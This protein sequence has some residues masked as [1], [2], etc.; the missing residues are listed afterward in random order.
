MPLKFSHVVVCT[1]PNKKLIFIFTTSQHAKAAT[2]AAS[3]T[4]DLLKLLDR[5]R[6]LQ[7][8]ADAAAY[9]L[10]EAKVGL[11]SS[12][13]R[14]ELI[15]FTEIAREKV[16]KAQTHFDKTTADLEEAK[17]NLCEQSRAK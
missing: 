7:E 3:V 16:I 12:I 10:K 13:Q 15:Q 14:Q 11:V 4:M 1:Q 17:K 2:A 6:K 9:Q 5:L 8:E